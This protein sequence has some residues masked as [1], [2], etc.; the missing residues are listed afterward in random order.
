MYIQKQSMVKIIKIMLLAKPNGQ[1]NTFKDTKELQLKQ[2][3]LQLKQLKLKLNSNQK[4]KTN[5]NI[6]TEKKAKTYLPKNSKNTTYKICSGSGTVKKHQ[7][8]RLI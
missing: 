5:D 7:K 4:T 2:R 3:L 8:T 1:Q 6:E